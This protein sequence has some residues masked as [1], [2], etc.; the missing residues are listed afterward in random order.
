[1]PR[2]CVIPGDGIGREVI[3]AA[4]EVLHAVVP[5]LQ[6]ETAEAGWDYFLQHGTALPDTTL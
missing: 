4:V 5:D 6:T 3:P 2:L 1:M